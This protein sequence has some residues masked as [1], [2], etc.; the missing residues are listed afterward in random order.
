MGKESTQKSKKK[1][2]QA[3]TVEVLPPSFE[4]AINHSPP[5]LL[6]SNRR[7]ILIVFIFAFAIRLI[8]IFQYRTDPFFDFPILD[9]ELYSNWAKSIAQ[10]DWIG[11]GVFFVS[12][13]YAYFLAVLY[14]ITDYEIFWVIFFQFLL[15]SL[16][17][18]LIYLIGRKFFGEIVGLT[19]ALIASLYGYFLFNEAQLLKSPLAYVLTTLS[20]YVFLL[21]R[22][23]QKPF[24]WGLLGMVSGLTAL[25]IPNILVLIPFLYGA[26]VFEKPARQKMLSN[27]VMLSLGLCI[28][29]APVTL[30]NHYVGKDWVL[31]SSNGGMNLFL[32]TSLETDGGLRRTSTIIEQAPEVEEI[33][34]RQVAEKDLKRELKPSEVSAY[35]ASRALKDI[36]GNV[37]ASIRLIFR[38]FNRFWN[39]RELNDNIDFYYFREK[40]LL[41][42][43]PFMNFGFVAPLAFLG[44]WLARKQKDILIP[45]LVFITI[46]SL[47][48]TPFGINGRYRTPLIPVLIVFAAYGIHAFYHRVRQKQWDGIIIASI[49]LV[50][51]LVILNT[52]KRDNNY[53]FMYRALGQ[54]YLKKG[55]REKSLLALQNSVEAD[56]RNFYARNALGITLSEMGKYEDAIPQF[57]KALK[58]S[59]GFVDAHYYLGVAYFKTGNRLAAFEEFK[60]VMQT[61]TT[62]SRQVKIRQLITSGN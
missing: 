62:G 20:F 27:L 35:W 59:P 54:I 61:D 29:I 31:I 3:N 28:M 37:S 14:M 11:N 53:S 30:R 57:E 17:C 34:S 8:F 42:G 58:L 36:K 38:K 32:G 6:R 45:A 4:Q 44:L 21:A 7:N 18:V 23:S 55:E 5:A 48:S 22:K 52:G 12:P 60:T 2:Q 50:S 40:Y 10:G 24:T 49:I 19:A 43:I 56:P 39:W 25:V 33:S 1:L 41:L 9:S 51:S 15:G 26:A 13:L 16:N 47:S 46:F